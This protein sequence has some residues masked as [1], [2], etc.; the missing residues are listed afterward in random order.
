MSQTPKSPRSAPT[1]AQSPAPR[2]PSRRRLEEERRQRLVIIVTASAL[3][4]AL[5]AVVIGV[6]YEQVWIPSRPVAQVGSITLT[7]SDYWREQRL[8]YARQIYQNFQL[9]DLF[10]N[11]PQIAQQFQGR[12]IVI[13]QQIRTLRRAE[14]NEQTVSEWIDRQIKQRA[15]TEFGITIGDD[16]IMQTAVADLA[17]IFLPA[18][19]EPTPTPDANATPVPT[20]D[21]SATATPEPTA[22]P[23]PTPGGPTPTPEPSPTLIPTSTPVPTPLPEEA[24]VQF[25]QIVDE[26]YRR[27]ELELIVSETKP[28]LSKEEFRMALM[29]QYR[30]RL[31]NERIQA[32]LV[33][34]DGFTYSTEP[35][36]VTARQILIAVKPP[37]EATP[38]QIEAAF[39]AAL[40]TAQE[41][42]TQLRNG[43]D[44][45]ALAAERSDD[46]GSRDNGGDIGSFDRNGFADN[47]ATYPPELVA[48]AFALPV[49]QISDPVRTQ[50]G[51]HIL[52]VTNRIVPSE[53][54]QLQKARTKALDEWIAEQRAKADIRRFPEP[55]PTPTLFPTESVPTPVPTY[56]PGPPTPFP[57]PTLAPTIEITPET[58]PEPTATPT[59]TA[60]P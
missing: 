44:F 2:R 16:E 57:T 37:A 56:L 53:A 55:T 4:I 15:S 24:R 43:A 23:S 35:E 40:P 9:L 34:E 41:L 25:D 21:P 1:P 7:R 60:T 19:P 48:A 31:L 17:F 47:G 20:V 12:S 13:D 14:I 54:D 27:Y 39:A 18:L 8:A 26:I 30:D 46:P 58:T 36:R 59:A 28:E 45:A 3:A 42:V 49:N 32:Q 6:I 38:E 52:E 50:F 10:G 51:W 33:P 11:N 29:E 22:T 5:L